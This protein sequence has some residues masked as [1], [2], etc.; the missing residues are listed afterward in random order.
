MK[1][2]GLYFGTFNPVH[3]GHLVIANFMANHTDLEEV[4]MVVTP[5][6][7]L[8]NRAELLPDEHRLQMVRLAIVD[9]PKVWASDVEFDLP[10][11][12]FTTNTL[13]FLVKEHSDCEFTLI[14]GEDNLRS[15]DKWKDHNRILEQF[16]IL[17]YPIS[18]TEG[19][20]RLEPVN[21]L[22]FS[23]VKICDAPMIKISSTFL[24]NSIQNQK[25]VRY[26]IPDKVINYI[27]N[28]YLYENREE[29]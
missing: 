18:Q 25:D 19:E 8:K 9:N 22:D 16:D 28:N 24:R 6:N 15:L 10:Q 12:N 5:H 23:R 29:H 20:T 14:M 21:G 11:P 2:I 27:S 26:L 3:I 4:W 7:P 17:V 1:K 13:D